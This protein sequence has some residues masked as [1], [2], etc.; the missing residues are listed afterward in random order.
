[1]ALDIY[2][3]L[4]QD[5]SLTALSLRLQPGVNADQVA[6]ELQDRLA[7]QQQLLIR[8]NQALRQDVMEVFDRTFAIT[9]ALRMLATG[10]AFIGVL[11]ALLLLQLEKQREVGILRALGLTGRELWRLVMVE[12]GSD[13][14]GRRAAGDADRLRAGGDPGLRH[15]P[16]LVWLDSADGGPAGDFFPGAGGCI[17]RGAAGRYL[18]GD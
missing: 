7:G 12:T 1:M 15:Q 10:V 14:A 18:P 16:A 5:E 17:G 9:V 3:R 11:N 2:R 13:G 8:P 6:R 4:W